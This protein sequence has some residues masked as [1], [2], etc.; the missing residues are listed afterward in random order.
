ML[1]YYLKKSY[2]NLKIILRQSYDYDRIYDNLKSW[3]Y[4]NFMTNVRQSYDKY[5]L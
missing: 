3:S 1:I 4:D 2:D 5:L